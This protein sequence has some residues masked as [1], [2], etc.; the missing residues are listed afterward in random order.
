MNKTRHN[1]LL[2]RIFSPSRNLFPMDVTSLQRKYE[3]QEGSKC[4]VRVRHR[5][6]EGEILMLFRGTM[7]Y[8][9]RMLISRFKDR[10]SFSIRGFFK[11]VR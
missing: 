10:F 11:A 1:F 5:E 7:C 8:S 2:A 6:I 3:A 9:D 4:H